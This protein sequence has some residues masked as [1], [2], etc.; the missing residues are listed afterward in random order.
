MENETLFNE[1][2][3]PPGSLT[4]LLD[5]KSQ[6]RQTYDP[7]SAFPPQSP[8]PV[9]RAAVSRISPRHQDSERSHTFRKR[10]YPDITDEQWHDWQWQIRNRIRNA[11]DLSRILNLSENERHALLGHAGSAGCRHALLCRPAGQ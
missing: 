1:E 3:E 10:F 2:D 8:R 5:F 9:V 4:G 6:N 7:F 11:N